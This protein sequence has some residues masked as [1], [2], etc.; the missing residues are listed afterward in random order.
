MPKDA[1][2]RRR[3][4]GRSWQE[5]LERIMRSEEEEVGFIE[6]LMGHFSNPQTLRELAKFNRRKITRLALLRELTRYDGKHI[7]ESA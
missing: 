4:G 7:E 6:E 2:A 3:V 1:V 5:T